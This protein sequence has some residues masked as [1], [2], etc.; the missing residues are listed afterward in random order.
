MIRL[1]VT[2][3]NLPADDSLIKVRST[4]IILQ[5]RNPFD[6]IVSAQLVLA[7]NDQAAQDIDQVVHH[8]R[9]WIS[10]NLQLMKKRN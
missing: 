10:L 8:V 9:I 6:V 2:R 4:P 7:S 5:I 3:D 1:A